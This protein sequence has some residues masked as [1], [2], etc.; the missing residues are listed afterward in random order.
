MLYCVTVFSSQR[1]KAQLF[2]VQLTRLIEQLAPCLPPLLPTPT[3][4]GCILDTTRCMPHLALFIRL[5]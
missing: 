2:S 5:D 4:V 1:S 3:V